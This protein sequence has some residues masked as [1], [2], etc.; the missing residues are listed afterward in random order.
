MKFQILSV[1]WGN[2]H[3]DWFKKGC[4]ESLSWP[5]NRK[6]I[7]E[8]CSAWNIYTE[9]KFFTEIMEMAEDKFSGLKVKLRKTDDL[10]RYSDFLQSALVMQIQ[11]CLESEDRFLFAPPDTIFADGTVS[12]LLKLGR[13]KNSC[14][15]IAHPR[16]L[17]E[18]L[19]EL[20]QALD[21]PKLVSLSWKHLHRSWTD[22]ETN[23]PRQNSFVGG[24]KWQK[25]KE[26]LYS[27]THRL[28]T[29]YLA[30]FT[31][32]DL[33]YFQTCTGFGNWDHQWA[34]NLYRQGRQ[35]YAGSSDAGFI[36]EL[37]ESL[38][39]IPPVHPGNVDEFWKND[40]HNHIN[41]QINVIFRGEA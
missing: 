23:H 34:I 24:V 19:P 13:E 14:V 8:N 7:L 33:M 31:K 10:R 21:G 1:F 35:R 17:P 12:N 15:A 36:I 37:T 18:I 27:V 38:K 25:L 41:K 16:V 29:T 4:F 6:A 39:N 40:E 9:E 30:D 26:N 11:E 32:E 28:P 2:Q 22:A 20:T 3:K 5:Q